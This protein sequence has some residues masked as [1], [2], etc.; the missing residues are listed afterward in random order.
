MHALVRRIDSQVAA[1]AAPER[2]DQRIALSAV[3]L[4][5]SADVSRKVSLFH[6][7][8][9]DR[10]AKARRLAV[11][12]IARGHEGA[13]EASR[14]Y[15]VAEPKS[16]KERLVEGSDVDDTLGFIEA[17]E[18]SK[19]PAAVP[20]F[21]GIVVLDDPRASLSRP[22]QKFQSARHRQDDALGKLVRR[23]YENRTRFWCATD[24]F[25][26]VDAVLINRYRAHLRARR[27]EC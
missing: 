7:S 5:H 14:H 2:S 10:L 23:R 8:S 27:D 18:R 9:D 15:G 3:N 16:W 4:P 21:T 1:Q 26:D 22:S 20:E 11:H 25:G 24:A 19:R 6:E 17:L 13:H 12:E